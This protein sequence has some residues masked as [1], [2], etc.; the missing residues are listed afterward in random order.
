MG[1]F[2]IDYT[3]QINHA[4][5]NQTSVVSEIMIDYTLYYTGKKKRAH[6]V[7]IEE[8]TVHSSVFFFTM[9]NSDH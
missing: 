5:P 7:K 2:D 6:N 3:R 8:V 4:S 9:R 1:H